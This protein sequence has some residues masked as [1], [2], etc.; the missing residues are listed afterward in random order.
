MFTRHAGIDKHVAL[1]MLSSSALIA[2]GLTVR[3]FVFSDAAVQLK[4]LQQYATGESPSWN[5]L[6]MADPADLTHRT[7]E[8]ITWWPPATQLAALPLVK[9]GI[10]IGTAIQVVA[11]AALLVG[12]LGWMRWWRRFEL[13]DPLLLCAALVLPFMHYASNALFQY[14]AEVLAFAAVPWALLFALD[15]ADHPRR[16]LGVGLFAGLLYW[17]KYSSL[18]IAAS[19]LVFATIELVRD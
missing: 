14:S 15:V 17:V 19:V 12:V 3:P 10:P 6:V 11:S 13:P 1:A 4:A 5:R 8:W 2:I 18:F 16:A 7:S 9:T